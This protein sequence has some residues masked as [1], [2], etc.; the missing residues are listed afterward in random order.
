MRSAVGFGLVCATVVALAACKSAEQKC[1]E[2]RGTANAAWDGA[3]SFAND[4]VTRAKAVRSKAELTITREIE[5]RISNAAM[6][7]AAAQYDRN[8]DAFQRAYVAAQSALCLADKQCTQVKHEDAEARDQQHDLEALL[9]SIRGVLDAMPR[10]PALAK[11][12]SDAIVVDENVLLDTAKKQTVAMF[13]VCKDV[14]PA[15]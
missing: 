3:I 7:A 2:A 14:A 15:H 9:A 4:G 12:L 11:Q 6:A 1:A 8:T 5:P 10:D 13:N